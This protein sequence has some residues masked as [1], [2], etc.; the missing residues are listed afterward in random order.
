MNLPNPINNLVAAFNNKDLHLFIC[1]FTE[2][3]EVHDEGEDQ[4]A[5]GY[6]AIKAWFEGVFA[7]FDFNTE[8]YDYS[9]SV[10]GLTFKARVS[11][12]F[13]GS[14]L[15]F[16]YEVKMNENL[17]QELKISILKASYES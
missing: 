14:P 6:D 15:N 2:N 5:K 4:N 1:C 11:G 12:N 10:N 7:K 17:I 9:R 8:P 3:A 16:L 13:P